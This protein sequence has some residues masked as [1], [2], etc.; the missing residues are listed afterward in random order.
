MSEKEPRSIS[1]RVKM[2]GWTFSISPVLEQQKRLYETLRGYLSMLRQRLDSIFFLKGA[3][4]N[5]GK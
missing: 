2:C 4:C 3:L 1:S 5:F